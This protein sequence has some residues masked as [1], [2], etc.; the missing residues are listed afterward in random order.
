MTA[1]IYDPATGEFT[2]TGDLPQPPGWSLAVTLLDGRVAVFESSM[3]QDQP[4]IGAIWDPATGTFEAV[5]G[6][7]HNVIDATLLDDGRI[8][9]TGVPT[10]DTTWSGIYDPVVGTTIDVDAPTGW[11]PSTVRLQD[12]RVLVVGGLT[13]GHSRDTG[14]G[15]LAPAVPTVHLPVSASGRRLHSAP[16]RTQVVPTLQRLQMSTGGSR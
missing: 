9:L 6:L 16:I 8:L 10:R 5:R 7:P 14:G 2:E 3:D 4:A 13:D 1:E 15:Q 11:W 12:G